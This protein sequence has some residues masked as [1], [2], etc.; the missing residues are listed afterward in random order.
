MGVLVQDW[1]AGTLPGAAGQTTGP[2]AE[3]LRQTITHQSI[4]NIRIWDLG[5]RKWAGSLQTVHKRM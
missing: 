2:H 3:L 5:L 1:R 4:S